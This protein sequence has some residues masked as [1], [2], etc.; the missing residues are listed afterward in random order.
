MKMTVV[1]DIA[2][3]VSQK[4]TDFSEGLTGST[5][6]AM[7][8]SCIKTDLRLRGSYIEGS[9]SELRP[10]AGFGISS[11]YNVLVQLTLDI[12]LIIMYT[13]M[14]PNTGYVITYVY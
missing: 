5:I 10:M 13:Y 7:S 2:R 14:S 3:C 8:K 6:S 12:F 9:G 11:I 1:W 4:L